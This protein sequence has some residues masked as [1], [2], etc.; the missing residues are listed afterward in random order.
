MLLLGL[1]AFGLIV[2]MEP[3]LLNLPSLFFV[4]GGTFSSLTLSF[5]KELPEALYAAIA[6]REHRNVIQTSIAVFER[7][8]TFA[9]IWGVAGT[10]IGKIHILAHL[11]DPT[12]LG[13]GMALSFIT[14]LYA[15]LLACII[16]PPIVDAQRRRLAEIN[17]NADIACKPSE[18]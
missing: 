16:F 11:D 1:I 6:G 13:P 9:L 12:M 8:K 3:E 2:A 10:L 17:G 15:V 14:I 7:G 5:G 4:L 18:T